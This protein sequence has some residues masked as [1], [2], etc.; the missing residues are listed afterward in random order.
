MFNSQLTSEC[1]LVQ[2]INFYI[3]EIV[4]LSIFKRDVDYCTFSKNVI[5]ICK[6]SI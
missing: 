2:K 5:S 3:H 6:K 1:V 4:N